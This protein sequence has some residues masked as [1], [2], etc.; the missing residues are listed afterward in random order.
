M[1][2]PD[3]LVRPSPGPDRLSAGPF[4]TWRCLVASRLPEPVDPAPPAPVEQAPAPALVKLVAP[5][6]A[7][8]E[9]AARIARARVS[10][11]RLF[12]AI[13]SPQLARFSLPWTPEVLVRAGVCAGCAQHVAADRIEGH[14][15][16]AATKPTPKLR[17]VHWAFG[18]PEDP[19]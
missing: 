14:A 19:A 1:R 10:M 5:A 8:H 4:L 17:C 16:S 13:R 6:P 12:E 9:E 11:A 18:I 3:P 2:V 15:V 7:P